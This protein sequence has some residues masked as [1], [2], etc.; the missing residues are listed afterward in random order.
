MALL[1]SEHVLNN[2]GGGLSGWH[3]SL[4]D[5]IE[6]AVSEVM[7]EIEHQELAPLA[8][9]NHVSREALVLHQGSIQEGVFRRSE[10]LV[11]S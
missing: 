6:A 3:V 4:S 7:L 8:A 5:F 2:F 9:N 11:E 10:G 1:V